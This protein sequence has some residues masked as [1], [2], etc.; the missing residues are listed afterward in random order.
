VNVFALIMYVFAFVCFLLAAFSHR[1]PASV[2]VGW[3]G[4]AF[5][6]LPTLVSAGIKVA[7]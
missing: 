2:A 6:I 1:A 3:L 5:A 7:G 4:L